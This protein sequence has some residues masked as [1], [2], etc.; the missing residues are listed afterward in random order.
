MAKATSSR[1]S[2]G[3]TEVSVYSDTLLAGFRSAL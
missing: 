2:S 1:E 3:K